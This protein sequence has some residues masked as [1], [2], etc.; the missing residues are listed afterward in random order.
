MLLLRAM[1][2]CIHWKQ[3]FYCL[4]MPNSYHT[5]TV[6]KNTSAVF[7]MFNPGHQ[8]T[9]LSTDFINSL[10]RALLLPTMCTK[11]QLES[12]IPVVYPTDCTKLQFRTC[13]TF[14]LW[15]FSMLI[16]RSVYCFNRNKMYPWRT[17]HTRSLMAAVYKLRA[18]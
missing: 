3:E 10:G 13:S 9:I 17:Y 14:I 15:V 6:E 2:F 12:S 16:V 7:V 18:E 1:K 5:T 4:P 11:F 8:H